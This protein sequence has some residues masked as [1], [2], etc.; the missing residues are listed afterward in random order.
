MKPPTPF[1]RKSCAV[2]KKYIKTG[3]APRGYRVDTLDTP[4]GPRTFVVSPEGFLVDGYLPIPE[5]VSTRFIQD[6]IDGLINEVI[7][8]SQEEVS[9]QSQPHHRYL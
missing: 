1:L 9:A 7:S 6:V 2:I 3:S 4:R 8:H 5:R